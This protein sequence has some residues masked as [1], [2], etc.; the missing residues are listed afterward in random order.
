MTPTHLCDF[1]FDEPTACAHPSC[2]QGAT[3]ALAAERLT[4]RTPTRPSLVGAPA[5]RVP[6]AESRP[7]PHIGTHPSLTQRRPDGR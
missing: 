7:V 1:C 3:S 4:P 5:T 6:I 2:P